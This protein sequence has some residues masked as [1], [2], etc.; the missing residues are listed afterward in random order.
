VTADLLTGTIFG[1][2]P[3]FGQTPNIAGIPQIAAEGVVLQS[4]TI[5]AD[6]LLATLTIDT[7]GFF[8]GDPVTSWTLNMSSTLNGVTD[9]AGAPAQ[10][11]DGTITLVPEPATLSL[12]G[13]GGLAMLRRRRRKG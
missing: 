8:A 9:F 5:S 10:I 3:N 12:L 2:Q 11:T 7:T 1:A 13:L 6:G 4:G